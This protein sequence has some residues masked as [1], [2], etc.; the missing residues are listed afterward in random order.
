MA[1]LI[2]KHHT[3]EDAARE[4]LEKQL[5]PDG[6]ACPKCGLVGEAYKLEGETTR[7][8]LYKCAGCREPFTVTMGTI[9]ED[10]H[11]PLHKWLFAIYL[12]C[13]SK[14]GIS[15]H[16]LWRNLWG[17]DESGKQL[18]SYK[19]AWFMAHRIRW[20]LGQEPVAGRLAGIV[21]VDETYIGGKERS[22]VANSKYS[23]KQ[24]VV[25]LLQRQG[26]VR[27]FPVD[28]I[29]LNNIEP[30]LK[31]HIEPEGQLMTDE[32][33]VYGRPQDYFATHDRVNHKQKQYSRRVNGL[34][35]T[36]NSVEGFFSLIKRGNYGTFHHWG[37]PYTQQYLNEFTFRYGTRKMSDH[38]RNAAAIQKTSGKR[39]TLKEP[40]RA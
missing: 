26:E 12:M 39:L 16:Q 23:K 22:G 10:S 27:A 30:V 8:G 29:T 14:K 17:T 25:A 4:Y 7:K 1:G 28:R 20:A 11:I 9:F 36:T 33:S 18:G 3:D 5:W 31:A 32:S 2:A 21:E 6:P 34:T 13:S 38:E 19:T 15:A 40:K 24:A 35:I 37:R